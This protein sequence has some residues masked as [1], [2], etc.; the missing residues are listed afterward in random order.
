MNVSHFDF[1][2]KDF[3]EI[4]IPGA[5][6]AGGEFF[7]TNFT[8]ANLSGVN[9]R[10][11]LLTKTNFTKAKMLNI[12]LGILPS[13]KFN[14]KLTFMQESLNKK[15]IMVGAGKTV[16][17]YDKLWNLKGEIILEDIA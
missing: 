12:E 4:K 6:L 14:E 8:K 3:S 7:E 11:A 10:S 16:F 13:I 2:G 9:F 5:D 1:S 17:I 15:L